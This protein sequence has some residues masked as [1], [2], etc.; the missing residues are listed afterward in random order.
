MTMPPRCY[1]TAAAKMPKRAG[2][3]AIDDR[4]TARIACARTPAYENVLFTILHWQPIGDKKSAAS[5]LQ[6]L[7]MGFSSG[8]AC[9]LFICSRSDLIAAGLWS[10]FTGGIP[11]SFLLTP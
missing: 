9:E 4:R 3:S 2:Y 8:P 1:V 7:G 6:H 10:L 11:Y 5:L